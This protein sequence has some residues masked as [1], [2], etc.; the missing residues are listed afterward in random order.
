MLYIDEF[1]KVTTAGVY[2]LTHAHLDHVGLLPL[3]F[4]HRVHC[5][6]FTCELL[7]PE[8]RH[9]LIP[10]LVIDRE[11]LVLGAGVT[12]SVLD[13][14][15]APGGVA[16]YH[17]ETCT[18]HYGDG[19]VGRDSPAWDVK[20]ITFDGL[21]IDQV[22]TQPTTALTSTLIRNWVNAKSGQVTIVLRH[23]GQLK[24]ME[25]LLDL[26]HVNLL[27]CRSEKGTKRISSRTL[28]QRALK[29]M[30]PASGTG[31]I[32]ITCKESK[33]TKNVLILS[34]LWFLVN[35]APLDAVISDGAQDRLY[36]SGHAS[37]REIRVLQSRYP[38]ATMIRTGVS[39]TL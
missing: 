37:S 20:T 13:N 3:T 23:F 21:F 29:R 11:K 8:Y 12:V 36:C 16:V 4:P 32:M 24:A 2:I 22:R 19:R 7:D 26:V 27:M 17:W 31:K 39:G 35:G 34:A 14:N 1:G 25:P 5:T 33:E 6:P 30:V 9:I 15:H 38:G 10:S 18:L 28:L